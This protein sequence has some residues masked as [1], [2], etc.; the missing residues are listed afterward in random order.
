MLIFIC[1][2][3][4][5]VVAEEFTFP[6]PGGNRAA[7]HSTTDKTAFSV[8]GDREFTISEFSRHQFYRPP[9]KVITIL[10]NEAGDLSFD[11]ERIV[12]G[13]RRLPTKT[14][15]QLRSRG[16]LTVADGVKSAVGI[17]GLHRIATSRWP[18]I[19]RRAF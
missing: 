1:H 7:A 17:E 5:R 14:R 8:A 2:P 10:T 11:R 16:E 13:N 12:F 15:R 19:L 3:C 4:C 6:R 18:L 9:G